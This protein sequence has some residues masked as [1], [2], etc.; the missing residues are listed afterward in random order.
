MWLIGA[1]MISQAWDD[2]NL[3]WPLQLTPPTTQWIGSVRVLWTLGGSEVGMRCVV[4]FMALSIG[5]YPF[6]YKCVM[7]LTAVS[8]G[9]H[10]IH[11]ICGYKDKIVQAWSGINSLGPLLSRSSWC[12]RCVMGHSLTSMYVRSC[13]AVFLTLN[14]HTNDVKQLIIFQVPLYP[15][16]NRIPCQK[17]PI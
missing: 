12:G 5:F 2:I 6:R 4:S 10:P 3:M 7:V 16:Y 17:D 14:N 9:S 11:I 8:I 15:Y 1:R 13:G